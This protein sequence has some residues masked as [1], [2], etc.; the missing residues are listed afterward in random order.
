MEQRIAVLRQTKSAEVTVD[1]RSIKAAIDSGED[2][3][4]AGPAI[5]RHSLRRS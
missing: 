4:G 5:G 2:V 1:R 3:P